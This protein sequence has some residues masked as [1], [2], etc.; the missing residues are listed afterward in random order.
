MNKKTLTV[1]LPENESVRTD[2]FISSLGIFSRSQIARR[3]VVVKSSSGEHLKLSRHLKNNDVITIEWDEPPLMKVVPQK[4]PLN[5][6]FEDENIVIVDNLKV[7]LFIL[8]T[9]ISADILSGINYRI[10]LQRYSGNI[11]R[12]IEELVV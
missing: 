4:I 1:N 8:R 5:I 11:K 7:W 10:G 6:V 9:A 3:A 12:S 2:K